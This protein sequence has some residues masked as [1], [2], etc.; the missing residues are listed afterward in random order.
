MWFYLYLLTSYLSI[1]YGWTAVMVS[2]EKLSISERWVVQSIYLLPDEMKGR[3]HQATTKYLNYTTH[4]NNQDIHWYYGLEAKLMD[5]FI[6]TYK[7]Y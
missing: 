4:E 3:I 2:N 5:E 7:V 6:N 1:P